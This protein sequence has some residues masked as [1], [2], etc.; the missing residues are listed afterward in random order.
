MAYSLVAPAFPGS[1]TSLYAHTASPHTVSWHGTAPPILTTSLLSGYAT[2]VWS[3]GV[4]MRT[5]RISLDLYKQV[6]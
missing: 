4:V 5:D 3:V 2:M 6:V 1:R